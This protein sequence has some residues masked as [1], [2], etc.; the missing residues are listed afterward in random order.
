MKY[1]QVWCEEIDGKEDCGENDEDKVAPPPDIETSNFS[2]I[3]LKHFNERSYK[4]LATHIEVFNSKE[5]ALI[6]DCRNVE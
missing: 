4:I 6:Q 1:V 3:F 2:N 5:N